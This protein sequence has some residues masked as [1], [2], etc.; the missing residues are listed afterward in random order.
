MLACVHSYAPTPASTLG[1]G[2]VARHRVSCVA[3]RPDGARRLVQRCRERACRCGQA[4]AWGCRRCRAE[5]ACRDAR[6]ASDGGQALRCRGAREVLSDLLVRRNW[7]VSAHRFVVPDRASVDDRLTGLGWRRFVVCGV[8]C[9]VAVDGVMRRTG[10]ARSVFTTRRGCGSG[11]VAA[12]RSGLGFRRRCRGEVRS[13]RCRRWAH[14]QRAA[15]LA[16]RRGEVRVIQVLPHWAGESTAPVG[17]AGA[18]GVGAGFGELSG[19]GS[20]AAGASGAG[21]VGPGNRRRIVIHGD[22]G[23]LSPG[24]LGTGTGTRRVRRRPVRRRRRG[25]RCGRGVGGD[26]TSG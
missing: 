6:A 26:V 11:G 13:G 5:S 9:A 18:S 19:V 16:R 3:S 8:R 17:G 22:V 20:S 14:R 25:C 7:R 12:G 24:Q 23:A 10:L 21:T 2:A 4:Y 15:P 1:T